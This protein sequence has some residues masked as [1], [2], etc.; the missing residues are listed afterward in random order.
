M[1]AEESRRQ[2]RAVSDLLEQQ[3]NDLLEGRDAEASSM[4]TVRRADKCRFQLGAKIGGPDRRRQRALW[5]RKGT[6]GSVTF[7]NTCI[8]SVLPCLP[9]WRTNTT[10]TSR[11]RTNFG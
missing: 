6:S 5:R 10:S 8:D 4:E 7:T 2:T 3:V 1:R 11:S 9:G